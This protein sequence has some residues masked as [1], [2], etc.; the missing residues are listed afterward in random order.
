MPP[1]KDS[2]VIN[3]P[4]VIADMPA[5][6][7]ESVKAPALV[8]LVTEPRQTSERQTDLFKF[9]YTSNC[10]LCDLTNNDIKKGFTQMSAETNGRGNALR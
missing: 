5:S 4:P 1:D 3:T 8:P 2:D 7:D 9:G 10:P 6:S